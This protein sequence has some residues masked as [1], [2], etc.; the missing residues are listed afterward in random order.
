MLSRFWDAGG[1]AAQA[2]EYDPAQFGA[3]GQMNIGHHQEAETARYWKL[4]FEELE[5]RVAALEL[6][7]L[8]S[9]GDT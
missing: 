4:R 2:F 9:T 7:A 1:M 5:K 6:A 8:Q 3:T